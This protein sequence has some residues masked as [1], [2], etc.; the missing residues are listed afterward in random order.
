[1]LKF[2]INLPAL[3]PEPNDIASGVLT[4]KIGDGEEQTIPT[5]K[6]QAAVEGLSGEQGATVVAS[7][8]YLDDA[9]NSSIEP[10]KLEAVL[11]DTIPPPNAG[12]LG[13]EVTAEE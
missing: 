5:T 3:P 4:L 6:Y 1:M 11:N 7:L 12:A 2:K 8:V 13:L 10:A 9:G